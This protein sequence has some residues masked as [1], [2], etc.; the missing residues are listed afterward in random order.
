MSV[1]RY[2]SNPLKYFKLNPSVKDPV[3]ATEGSACFDIHAWI[4][5]DEEIKI[6]SSWGDVRWQKINDNQSLQLSRSDRAMVPTGL[7]FDIPIGWSVRLHPRSGMVMKKAL[8][9]ANHEGVIDSEERILWR[10]IL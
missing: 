7:I 8:S 3:F 5:V 9:L 10:C 6:C 2:T 1:N 4:P